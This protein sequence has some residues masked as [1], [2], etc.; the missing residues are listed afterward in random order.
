MQLIAARHFTRRYFD[1]LRNEE[2]WKL[3]PKRRMEKFRMEVEKLRAQEKQRMKTYYA[4]ANLLLDTGTDIHNLT[5]AG[6]PL[7]HV[8]ALAGDEE[9]VR[10]LVA[11]GADARSMTKRGSTALYA[12]ALGA[13]TIPILL[14]LLDHGAD[15]MQ[16]D[17]Q[18]VD[19]ITPLHGAIYANCKENAEF[20]LRNGA[21]AAYKACESKWELIYTA[22]DDA[23]FDFVP[24][25]DMQEILLEHGIDP[26]AMGVCGRSRWACVTNGDIMA[27]IECLV[28]IGADVNVKGPSAEI[29]FRTARLWGFEDSLVQWFLAFIP[30]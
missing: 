23:D 18:R 11:R 20:L 1:R 19:G 13:N 30:D 22:A 29:L 8:A 14:F 16:I 4:I 7:L 12:A 26:A 24:H 6:Q 28:R 15:D 27:A 5:A 3:V 25:E 2:C 10:L 17:V 21:G 9:M